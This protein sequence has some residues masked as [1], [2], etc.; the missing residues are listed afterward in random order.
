MLSSNNRVYK[1]NSKDN[2]I[3]IDKNTKRLFY[4]L[5]KIQSRIKQ[6]KFKEWLSEETY[7]SEEDAF[8]ENGYYVSNLD[9]IN[10]FNDNI[11]LIL[12]KHGFKIK[13]EKEFKNELATFIYNLS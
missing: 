4:N 8:N 12:K 7:L 2:E 10:T 11:I 13:N 9:K 6:N 3:D 1:I 5:D